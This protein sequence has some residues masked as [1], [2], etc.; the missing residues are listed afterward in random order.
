MGG[1][2]DP[3]AGEQLSWSG[4]NVSAKEALMVIYE[5]VTRAGRG[6]LRTFGGIWCLLSGSLNLFFALSSVYYN[7]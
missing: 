4:G 2:N 3:W 1:W 5:H 7:N 6:D